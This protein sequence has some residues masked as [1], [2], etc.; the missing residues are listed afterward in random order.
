MKVPE[1]WRSW[2][3]A[4]F[5]FPRVS[6]ESATWFTAPRDPCVFPPWNHQV[7]SDVDYRA[8]RSVRFPAITRNA[9]RND[10]SH[11]SSTIYNIIIYTH[12][13]TE[14]PLL[15]VYAGC[16]IYGYRF[17]HGPCYAAAARAGLDKPFPGDWRKMEWMLSRS[18]VKLR[19]R[20][21]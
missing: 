3:L 11:F 4:A 15:W 10:N 6:K 19:G 13:Y 7:M 5:E 14:S 16:R 17:C 1:S 18:V 21:L 2:G 20:H 12:T 9:C 8:S